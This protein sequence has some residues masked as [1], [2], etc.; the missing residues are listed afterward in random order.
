MKN[1][2]KDIAMKKNIFYLVFAFMLFLVSYGCEDKRKDY[3]SFFNDWLE[4]NY[5]IDNEPAWSSDGQWISFYHTDKEQSKRGIYL[6][7]PDGKDIR[8]WHD[9]SSEFTV[10]VK[11]TWSPDGQWIA[12]SERDQIWKKKIDGDSLTQLTFEGRNFSPSWSP[13]GKLI[14]YASCA[15]KDN[16]NNFGI[17][18]MKND[19][20]DKEMFRY[21]PDVGNMNEPSWIDDSTIV[22]VSR[23][24]LLFYNTEIYTTEKNGK[25]EKRLTYNSATDLFPRYSHNKIVFISRASTSLDFNIW[26]MNVGG[27]NYKRLTDH[28]ASACDWSPD[29]KYIVYT[30]ARLDNGRLWI[31]DSSGN[32]KRQ[33][34]FDYHFNDF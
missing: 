3:S 14:A 17:Y 32:N 11:T 9:I 23:N 25:N 26:K 6:I 30:D 15:N 2:Y 31:M 12:F 28:R 13:N 7:S 18:T 19:G 33:L 20:Q 1:I 34:T 27:L 22:F 5:G 8:K 16:P 10:F 29:G 24:Y 4:V 21:E